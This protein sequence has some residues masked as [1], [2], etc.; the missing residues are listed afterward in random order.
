MQDDNI[1]QSSLGCYGSPSIR[2]VDDFCLNCQVKEEC[3]ALA[4]S[5]NELL[6]K[7]IRG[8]NK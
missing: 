4:L 3:L 2:L 1:N 6:Q 7:V 8:L 5:R